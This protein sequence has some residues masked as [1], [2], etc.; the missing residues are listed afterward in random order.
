MTSLDAFPW[1]PPP[2][3]T[4]NPLWNGRN[5]DLGDRI[6]RVLAYSAET[7]HWSDDLTFLHETEA[8]H[9]H[10]IDLA[11]RRLAVA[12]MK[13]LQA[14]APIIL[15][16]G[17][18]SGF[19][20]EDLRQSLPQAGLIG[21]DY[22]RGPLEGL[23]QRMPD[24]PIMQFDLRKCPL[25][26]ACVDGVTCLN[27]LE[28]ID[29]HA[30]ALA[31]IHRILKPG[32]L[33]HIEVPAGPA[34]YDIYDEHLLHHR[35]YRLADLVSLAR[36]TGFSVEKATHLGFAVYPAF[37]WVKNRNRRKLHLPVEQK[38]R[39]VTAQIRAT[40]VNLLFAALIKLE[41]L[42]GRHLSYPLGIR[43]VSVLRKS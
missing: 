38:K 21:A 18:S 33:A 14:H 1:P 20:L 12:S 32:G 42:I 37:W 3:N 9:D 7:S 41:T 10:P 16:V 36:Q 2:G 39:L 26:D 15:D 8:G 30:A 34:L 27:V 25:P 13:R 35:R 17:C 19:V 29:D 4:I 5:F 40:R 24:M 28:H 31:E 22:L 11:S 6:S 43:C 23:A